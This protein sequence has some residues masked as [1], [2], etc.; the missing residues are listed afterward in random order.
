MLNFLFV[1]LGGGLGA[2][3]RYLITL[4]NI[5]EPYQFPVKTFIVNILG[6]LVIGFVTGLATKNS[7][8]NPRLV[9][10]LKTGICGGFTTF[11]TFALEIDTLL[12]SGNFM[13]AF[14]YIVLSIVLGISTVF[15]G[16]YLATV[17]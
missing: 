3:L 11:S 7:D 9:L 17:K 8:M 10:F 15:L 4:A 12:K 16:Q 5:R 1:A 2:V 6:C 14:L 13:T